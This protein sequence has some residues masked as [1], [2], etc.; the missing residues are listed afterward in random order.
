MR[1]TCHTIPLAIGGFCLTCLS[2][3][4][5]ASAQSSTRLQYPQ[6]GRV[7]QSTPVQGSTT[8]ASGSGSTLQGS[9][10]RGANPTRMNPATVAKPTFESKFWRYLNDARYREWA[11][12]HGT[13]GEA[14][15]GQ[16]P[17]GAMLKMYLNRK[18]AGLPDQLPTGSVLVK[19][20]Y[21]ADGKTLMAVTTMFKARNYDPEGSG[22]YWTKYNPDGTVA[23]KDG[24]P[25]AGKVSGCIE[26]HSGAEGDDFA[27]FND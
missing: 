20:N 3:G 14:Y 5:V 17:H 18:A 25:L 10:N 19:E 16:S 9:T 6:Q 26:C 24:R 23:A 27:F 13:S 22:W 12:V 1:R 7:I 21:A 11:P 2:S 4:T 8:R 15:A